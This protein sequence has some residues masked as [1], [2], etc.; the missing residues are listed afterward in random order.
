MAGSVE[1]SA[2]C[3]CHRRTPRL[4]SPHAVFFISLS[5]PVLWLQV[6]FGVG[7]QECGGAGYRFL[8]WHCLNFL[9]LPQGQG[10]LRPGKFSRRMGCT[11]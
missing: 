3:V 7:G 1:T 6:S 8:P 11:G 5:F 4:P 2:R 9:P 10:S